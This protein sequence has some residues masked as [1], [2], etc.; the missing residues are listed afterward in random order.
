MKKRQ[1]HQVKCGK[2]ANYE[3]GS[4]AE[5]NRKLTDALRRLGEE[6]INYRNTRALLALTQKAFDAQGSSASRWQDPSLGQITVVALPLNES[7]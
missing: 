7:L 4:V 1:V 5:M 3:R 2:R 6:P